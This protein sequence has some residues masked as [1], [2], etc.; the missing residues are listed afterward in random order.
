MKNLSLEALESLDLEKVKQAIRGDD[1][2]Q[3]KLTAKA[4]APIQP[5]ELLENQLQECVTWSSQ[6]RLRVSFSS[7]SSGLAAYLA[8]PEPCPLQLAVD[9]V[10]RNVQLRVESSPFQL[11]TVEDKDPASYG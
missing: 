2:F 4:P 7:T 3:V 11:V 8:I 1:L 6:Q 5:E 10:F 9:E